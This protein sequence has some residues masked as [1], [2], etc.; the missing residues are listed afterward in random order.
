MEIYIN[1]SKIAFQP[2][3]PLTWGNF[4]QKLLENQNYIPQDHGIVAVSVDEVDSLTLMTEQ[5]DH[6]L[7][8]NINV[9]RVA[10]K[11]SLTITRDGFSKVSA[12][13]ENIKREI[14]NA[15]DFY[16][17]GKTNDGSAKIVKIMEAIKPIVN[18][19]NS[20]GMSFSLDFDALPY[21]SNTTLREKVGQFLETLDQLV[22]AQ[23]KQDYVEIA[24]Y[25]EYR[26]KEDM[27]GWNTIV[28]LLLR[29]IEARFA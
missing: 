1:G 17:Q 21:D 5:S 8:E 25:L 6:M 9:I 24:D 10:T 29:E 16:R 2:L 20:V 19:I 4:F 22:A 27:N 18:F 13:L 7:P 28:N 26:L 23:E 12:L 3:F 11:D 14:L 15:A